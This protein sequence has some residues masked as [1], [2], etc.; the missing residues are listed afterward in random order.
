MM[1]MG[2]RKNREKQQEFWV[3]TES[4]PQSPGHPLYERLNA[5]LLED[6][7]DAFVEG[8]CARFYAKK[9]GRPSLAPAVYFRLV[10]IG[11]FEGLDS[12]REIAWRATDSMSIRTFLGIRLTES[13]PDHSTIS[14]TRRL[15][16]EETHEA[17]SCRV[18]MILTREGLLRGKT[19]GI[20]ATTLEA[21]AAMRSIKR[22]DTGETYGDFTK[23]LARESG[24]EEPTRDD[25]A[26]FDRKRKKKTS[27]KDWEH[28]HDPDA[29]VAK[30]KDGRTHMAHKVEHAIDMESGA[31]VAVTIQ[32]ADRGDTSSVHH[33]LEA[34]KG[35]LEDILDDP[36]A[37][38]HVSEY[39]LSEV[40]ADKGYHS[41]DVLTS[42]RGEGIRTYISEPDRGLRNWKNKEEEKTA[43]Y[44]N[45][46]RVRGD[47]GR[48]LM[49]DRGEK[50]ERSFAH[51]YETGGMRRTHLRGHPNILKRLLIHTAA[52]NLGIL[53]RRQLGCGTPRGLR[54][55]FSS[56]RE[57]V[58]K[59]YWL[60]CHRWHL[61]RAYRRLDV[62]IPEINALALL[63]AR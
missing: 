63:E 29:K 22:R 27:N 20:D 6:G 43:V 42:Q 25:L 59:L 15:I 17:V 4:L 54:A 62:Y 13:A 39:A 28:P 57:S 45:R 10:M 58:L 26:R 18:Q 41:N 44:A 8:L 3:A 32:P 53:L 56:L 52:F 30:M 61:L 21:N 5:I 33:T 11:Y 9:M 1:S 23:R 48:Q 49:R 47:R 46:R 16:D 60:L 7:F 35:T 2:K 36:E 24:I 40:V 50:I 38:K 14:R 19:I 55:L 34:V 37:G 51:C 31:I 12:D